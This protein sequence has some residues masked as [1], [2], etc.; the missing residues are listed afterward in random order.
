[1]Q[2]FELRMISG[3]AHMAWHM[4][5]INCTLP[6]ATQKLAGILREDSSIASAQALTPL[7]RVCGLCVQ[8][9]LPSCL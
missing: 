4:L 8:V 7:V 1:M 9:T 6:L 5:T 3:A 2:R